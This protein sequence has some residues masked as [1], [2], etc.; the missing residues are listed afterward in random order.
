VSTDTLQ[1]AL[2]AVLIYNA[3]VGFAY[4]LYRLNKGGPTA[5]AVGQALLGAVL[6]GA[7]VGVGTGSG[8]G[9]W[10]ALAYG[11][12]F[13]IVVMPIWVLAVLIPSRPGAID[14]AFTATYWI[15]LLGSVG[16]ALALLLS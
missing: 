4:R 9:R 8:W 7:A 6:V 12:L 10:I 15:G 5:D 3:G 11:G 1:T 13:G 14:Y 16:L 2:V